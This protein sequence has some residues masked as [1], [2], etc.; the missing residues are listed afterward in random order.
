MIQGTQLSQTEE[1]FAGTKGLNIFFRSWRSEEKP[2]C[3][4]AIVPGFNSH[5]GY[6]SSVAQHL[7]EKK[8]AVYA[9]DLRGR[10]QS[11]GER[12]FVEDINEYVSDI[13]KLVELAKTREPGVPVFLLGHSAGGVAACIYA[14]EHQ[15]EIAGLICESFAYQVPAPDFALAALKGLSHVFPHAHVL[16]LKI[17]DFSRVSAVTTAM[18]EDPLVCDEVQPT[19]TVA[20]MVIADERLKKEFPMIT[21]PVLILHGRADKVTRPAGSEFFY[22]YASSPDKTLKLYERGY[23]DLLNDMDRETVLSDITTWIEQRLG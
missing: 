19:Q 21:L 13:A 10:G 16:R 7:V 11:D 3:V 17:D 22:E 18:K 8:F 6:Y 15:Q 12:Y 4:V 14:L 23:H 1:T 2:K 9:V 5:S 20:Q